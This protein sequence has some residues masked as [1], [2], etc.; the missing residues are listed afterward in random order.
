ME[1]RERIREWLQDQ[2]DFD[3]IEIWNHIQ[4]EHCLEDEIYSMND[5]EYMIE[6]M[7]PMDIVKEFSSARHFD[8]SDDWF[9]IDLY[10]YHSFD[11]CVRVDCPIDID[12]LSYYFSIFR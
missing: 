3:L 5:L 9:H 8:I 1:R 7:E 12:D 6:G 11:C 10:G 4:I 2:D